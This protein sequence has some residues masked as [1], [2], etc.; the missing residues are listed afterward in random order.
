[1]RRKLLRAIVAVGLFGLIACGT[2]YA[3]RIQIGSL[4]VRSSATV[5]PRVL[6]EHRNVG[7]TVESK[8]QISTTDGSTPPT[9]KTITF[10]FDKHGV[11]DTA[12]LPVCT[13]AKL[14]E[15]TTAE[16]K[17]RCPGAIVG[18]GLGRAIVNLPGQAAIAISSPIVLFN[19]PA[20]NG[21]PSLIAHAYETVPAPKA[22]LVPFSIERIQ[23][24]RYGYRVAV[25]M[26]E[27]A[28]GYGAATLAEAKLGVTWKRG[29]K[30]HSY[31]SARCEGGR[32][33][34]HGTLNFADGSFFQ[35]TLAQSCAAHG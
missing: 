13:T 34:S 30:T 8:T 2:A 4:E 3:L 17:A 5:L 20:A 10:V 1:M 9:L 26:P 35:G 23:R 33:Q 15:T 16:A 28:E 22:L 31:I 25:K 14:A 18:E 29:G 19:A 11:I 6:P 27:I 24:G 7:V 32:L 12:G 21:A